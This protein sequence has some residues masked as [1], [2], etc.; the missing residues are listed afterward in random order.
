MRSRRVKL[1]ESNC[2]LDEVLRITP[3]LFEIHKQRA[4]D[5]RR[6]QAAVIALINLAHL[7]AAVRAVL[8][9]FLGC[10]GD[11]LKRAYHSD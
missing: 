4:V 2:G 9:G 1:D 10:A 3:E 11:G 7:G 8:W 6:A 5:A